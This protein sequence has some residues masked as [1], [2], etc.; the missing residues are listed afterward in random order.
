MEET[1][2]PS[3]PCWRRR[4]MV[5]RCLLGFCAGLTAYVTVFG[6]DDRVRETALIGAL[7]LMGAV[8]LGYLGFAVQDDKNWLRSLRR[9]ET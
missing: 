1:R 3:R 4:W 7:G 5:V 2:D 9:P 6:A 8:A